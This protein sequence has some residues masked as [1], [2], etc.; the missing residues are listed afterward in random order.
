MNI[1]KFKL[2]NA[3]GIEW[4]LMRKD[5]FL[6]SP[7]GLGIA[8]DNEYMR[9]GNTYD[10]VQR[11]SAQKSVN[12]TMAFASYAVYRQFV[13]FIVYSPLKLAYMPQNEWVYID[14]DITSLLKTEIDPNTNR[15]LCGAVFTASSL[16]YIPKEA[17]RTSDDVPDAKKYTYSYNYTY[18]DAINGYIAVTNGSNEDAPAKIT[19]IGPIVNPSWYVSVNNDVVA[20]GS[21]TAT[22]PS[23][24]KLVMV[25]KDGELEVSEY[26]VATNEFVRNLYQ[27]T[28]FSKET[29]VLFPPGNSVLFISGT[30]DDPIEAWVQIDEVHNSV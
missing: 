19:I 2:I 24:N 29:F 17:R 22:I 9:I 1:R 14:G 7:E 13:D 20:S 3:N 11:L 6:Y 8:Q 25:S 23:G 4:D 15:L 21:V 10:L 28:D 26:V 12:F 18:A 30:A 16:W 27:F 5:A